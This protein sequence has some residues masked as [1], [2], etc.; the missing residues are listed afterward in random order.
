MVL[1]NQPVEIVDIT[2][3]DNRT[4]TVHFHRSTH[5]PVRQSYVWRDPKIRQPNEEVT[6]FSKYRDVGGGVQW[7]YD[8]ERLRNGDRVFQ[9]YAD[10]VTLN[11]SLPDKLFVLPSNIKMLKPA[12]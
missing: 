7:P 9:I 11:Q 12:R 5:L 10:N 8:V 1:E 2:D 3:S 6:I 4:V